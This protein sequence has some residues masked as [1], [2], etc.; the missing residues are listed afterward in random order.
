[1]KINKYAILLL[2]LVM[3]LTGYS[4]IDIAILDFDHGVGISQENVSGLQQML[5]TELNNT[6][7]FRIKERDRSS[8]LLAELERKKG[9]EITLEEIKKYGQLLGVDAILVGTINYQ[10]RERTLED[11]QTDM[12]KGEYN[13]DA[14]L[15]S[16]ST[17]SLLSTGGD[18]QHS[19]ETTRSLMKRIAAQ[20]VDNYSDKDGDGSASPTAPIE[21][22]G[23]L[24]V[25][26]TDLG[27]FTSYPFD[28]I[29]RLNRQASLGYNDWR[30]P[31]KEELDLML[32]NK[33][34]SGLRGNKLYASNLST[35]SGSEPLNVRLVRS[36]VIVSETVEDKSEPYL[37]PA[38]KNF[39][40]VPML[41]RKVST[42]FKIVNPTSSPLEIEGIKCASS[43]VKIGP[44]PSSIRPGESIEIN[45]DIATAKRQGMTLH[46]DV[47]VYI[48]DMEP[49]IFKIDMQVK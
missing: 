25:Y 8:D 20:L 27:V 11:V 39:G 10:V 22:L 37:S 14:R 26:P 38:S 28:T 21:M 13:V 19:N 7:E 3:Q 41:K 44:Y 9:S 47:K 36:K 2:L 35:F 34:I 6:K 30:L 16:V 4:Q 12:S 18:M 40:M 46:R 23:Y 15:V 24:I 32:S 29:D 5:T 17:G 42:S 45:L 1:M 33:N 49:L 31:S 48:K 43:I